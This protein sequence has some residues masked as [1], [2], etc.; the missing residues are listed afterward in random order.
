MEKFLM[1]KICNLQIQI[2]LFWLVLFT[3]F[4]FSCCELVLF[5]N[6]TLSFQIASHLL[7]L[8]LLIVLPHPDC[9]SLSCVYLYCVLHFV[10]IVCCV[11]Q[12][13]GELSLPGPS[14]G[15]TFSFFTPLFPHLAGFYFVSFCISVGTLYYSCIHV[16]FHPNSNVCVK[17]FSRNCYYY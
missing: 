1:S 8:C 13:E 15:T 16:F 17:R 6:P 11:S 2:L 3:A 9:S 5:W 10:P 4:V 14:R 12:R 7:F